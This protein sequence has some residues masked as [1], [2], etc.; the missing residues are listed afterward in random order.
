MLY[1]TKKTTK[2]L[3]AN[4]STKTI[5]ENYRDGRVSGATKEYY[6]YRYKV[7]NDLEEMAQF[8]AFFREYTAD[9][10]MLDPVFRIEGRNAKEGN[11]YAIKCFTRIVG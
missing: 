2:T 4:G 6:E 10:T 1:G 8:N 3:D 5:L 7:L 9:P 11:R